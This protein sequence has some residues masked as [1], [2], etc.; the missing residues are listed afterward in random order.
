[1]NRICFCLSWCLLTISSFAQVKDMNVS[2]RITDAETGEPVPFASVSFIKQ[3][4]KNNS[5]FEGRY[6]IKSKLSSDSIKV[7][8][9]GYVSKT[10]YIGNESI[11][12][13]QLTPQRVELSTAT[14][15]PKSNPAHRIMDSLLAR[16]KY[17][18]P[19]ALK[20][21]ECEVFTRIELA[22]NN[23][24]NTLKENRL[25]RKLGA[26]LDSA[27]RIAGEDGKLV[28]PVF[29]SETVSDYYYLANPYKTKEHIKA[30]KVTGVGVEDGSTISQL[31]GSVFQKY[32]FYTDWILVVNKQLPS[33]L[34]SF[35][36][37]HYFL[38]LIDS[39]VVDGRKL[40]QIQLRKKHKI[41]LAFTGTIWIEDSS[42]A[43][44][45]LVVTV[46]KSAN[47]NFIE[48]I[49]LQQE[50]AATDAGPWLA[51]KTRISIDVEQ[52]AKN[53][54]GFL[55]K[56]YS[57]SSNIVCDSIRAASFFKEGITISET[58]NS[59]TDSFWIKQRTQTGEK[60]STIFY[61]MVDSLKNLK[62]VK[63]YVDYAE[64]IFGGYKRLGKIDIGS[65][66]L[67]YSHNI[68]EGN[69]FRI[70]ARTN[71]TFNRNL[72]FNGY[73]AYGTLDQKF[74]YGL[75][76]DYVYKRSPWI[77]ITYDIK[78]DIEAVGL[79]SSSDL[80]SSSSFFSAVSLF[81]RINR[82]GSVMSQKL[83]IEFAPI[84]ELTSKLKFE[85]KTFASLEPPTGW[86]FAYTNPSSGLLKESFTNASFT[87]ENSFSKTDV[88]I[89]NDN[90]RLNISDAK[91]A[92]Y[93]LAYTLGVK[94]LAGSDF[95]Y[96]KIRFTVKQ[97][98]FLKTLGSGKYQI[99]A[100]KVFN[101]LP[102]PMLDV[103]LGNRSFIYSSLTF[104]LMDFAEFVADQTILAEYEHNF[105]GSFLNRIKGVKNWKL[106][107]F[108]NARGAMGSMSEANKLLTPSF[109][110]YQKPLTTFRV[111]T[112]VPYI[113]TGYGIENIFKLIRVDFVHRL[114]YTSK[115]PVYNKTPRL[116]GVKLS[117]QFKF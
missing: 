70:G 64:I 8:A 9:L 72:Y 23:I 25:T 33:P 55:A 87:L 29:L 91:G 113:E 22:L 41:D 89:Q 114:T 59:K 4:V 37:T 81:T 116:F 80:S 111:F 74:K 53:T 62:A 88:F 63:T 102:Y 77:K 40:Y 60:E 51:T 68:I 100:S 75:G 48:K 46:D 54:S 18:N 95:D 96:H 86:N 76:V 49:K 35:Y 39:Q 105:E 84:K 31:T 85:Y 36:K 47:L 1:M 110:N 90:K 21:Y 15:K 65:Y 44:K 58:S 69:R 93:T 43:L 83:A 3:S 112:N 24:P 42:F 27:G 7:Q 78:K 109:D 2:G 61:Q 99:S 108:A 71:Y 67:F 117:L 73:L 6:S 98:I 82:W 92:T 103:L 52:P 50:F 57:T 19:E 11:I 66:L 32:N 17:N 38:K 20:A 16:K 94:G 56:Y 101:P 14:I 10:K 30:T 106:R 104:N 12:D 97:N 79:V 5:D 107:L 45:R 26:I 34:S 13:F 28:I 115:D